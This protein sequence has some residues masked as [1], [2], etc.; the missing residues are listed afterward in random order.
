MEAAD[1]RNAS[2]PQGAGQIIDMHDDTAVALG[3][4]KEAKQASFEDGEIA[5][6]PD[7]RIGAYQRSIKQ[8][9]REIWT[10]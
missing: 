3:G 8:S 2:V 7:A 6:G 5:D 4:A 10:R 1:D 9:S